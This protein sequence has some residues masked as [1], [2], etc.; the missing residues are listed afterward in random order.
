MSLTLPFI[1]SKLLATNNKARHKGLAQ[2]IALVNLPVSFASLKAVLWLGATRA[3]AIRDASLSLRV[4]LDIVG[5]TVTFAVNLNRA[6]LDRTLV[7][8]SLDV[9]SL[10][11][12]VMA[13]TQFL[14]AHDRIAACHLAGWAVRFVKSTSALFGFVVSGAHTATLDP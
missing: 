10:F 12:L 1:D 9:G 11:N 14:K 4:S 6:R 2:F 5:F 7:L 3:A 13:A 8:S